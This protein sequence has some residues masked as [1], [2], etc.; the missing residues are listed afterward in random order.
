MSI[1]AD[2]YVL[3]QVRS[4]DRIDAFLNHFLPERELVI[5]NWIIPYSAGSG[6]GTIIDDVDRLIAYC[7]DHANEYQVICWHTLR[8]MPP[9]IAEVYFT[10]DGAM[11]FCLSSHE[12]EDEQGWLQRLKD[13]V[14]T[15]I[16]YITY[17]NPPPMNAKAFM[18]VYESL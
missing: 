6:A 10:N 3:V 7:L 5:E 16:G 11:L 13:F 9:R 14:G 2:C 1:F 12:G 15:A 17:E 18:Q 4:R 8:D